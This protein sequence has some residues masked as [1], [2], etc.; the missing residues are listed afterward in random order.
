MTHAGVDIGGT[1]T[2]LVVAR[3]GRLAVYKLPSTPDDYS[4]AV[5]DGLAALGAGDGAVSHGSTVATNAL[6]ERRGAP[7][8]LITTRGFRD[9][10]AI[11]RQTRP[12]LYA[13]QPRRPEPL[14][15]RHWRREV[16]ERGA[17]DGSVI[18]A[19]DLA[20]AAAVLD[21]LAAEG[22]ESV[23]ICLLFSFARPEH[24]RAIAALAAAR[25]LHVS[26][27]SRIL[28]EFREFERT[29]TTVVNAYV[30]PLMERYVARLAARLPGRPLRVMQSNGGCIDAATAGREAVRTVLS[31]PA[32]GLV[33]AWGVAQA[34]G[35]SRVLTFDMGGTS[36][37]VAVLD[38]GLPLTR[39]TEIAGLPIALPMLDIHTVGAGGGSLARRDAGGA[40]TVGPHSAGATPG[41][42]CY[43]RGGVEPTVTDAH[44]VLGRLPAD[45][46][47]GGRMT[48]RADLAHAAVA[49]LAGELG[50]DVEACAEGI[51]AV[52][53]A[54]LER[55]LR[56]ISVE[57]GL[58]PRGFALLAFGGAGGLHA[59]E[60]AQRLGLGEVL[61][62]AHAGALSA[63]GLLLADVVRDGAR[64]VM[65]PLEAARAEDLAALTRELAA[66][67]IEA[68]AEQGLGV[69]HVEAWADLRYRGQSFELS[70]PV[71]SFDPAVLAAD[72]HAA[73]ATRYGYR[74]DE[75]PVELVT[76][77]V[78]VVAETERPTLPP[79]RQGTP[80]PALGTVDCRLGEAR[81]AEL[82]AMES[83][84]QGQ[85]L[86][87]P[88]IVAGEA[89][90]VLVA[91]GW[92]GEVDAFGNL[93]LRR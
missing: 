40:L 27:S 4:R 69:P 86:E 60:L 87:G 58:D 10:L 13:L 29:A 74:R 51:L 70:R 46:F 20:E 5:L 84:V 55:A 36:T 7:T 93:R 82:W 89:T 23:A 49:R 43:D 62:P 57:R 67:E 77:R 14:V 52:T 24:E 35:L 48:L 73:H 15:P 91:P 47:L 72:F 22:A 39:E 21:A 17:A 34:A 41:P 8:A 1:F 26:A 92:G 56:V 25:G 38:G 75:A 90:T 11:G 83:L 19:L 78:R 76:W 71:A 63:L 33:G 28:P 59:C 31:G 45:R 37:D 66:P 79:A 65:M 32:A 80:A 42:A 64:T 50:L 16:R 61:V 9:V 85:R 12:D 30:G 2:D 68:L 88:A 44:V 53:L 3:D 6:L 81:H 18:E 54:A